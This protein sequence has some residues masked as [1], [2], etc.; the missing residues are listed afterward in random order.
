MKQAECSRASTGCRAVRAAD[1]DGVMLLAAIVGAEDVD[2]AGRLKRPSAPG[3]RRPGAATEARA[4]A[5][6]A[7]SSGSSVRLP[8]ARKRG[9]RPATGSTSGGGQ[10]MRR[11]RQP[12]RGA[13]QVGRAVAQGLER[14]LHRR[15]Q[16]IGRVGDRAQPVQAGVGGQREA[17]EIAVIGA[18]LQR[19]GAPR[20]DRQFGRA[21]ARAGRPAGLRDSVSTATT[22][23]RARRISQ[24]HGHAHAQ[25][26]AGAG[27]AF[28]DAGAKRHADLALFTPI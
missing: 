1:L 18:G 4:S 24:H 25:I 12:E 13:V 6:A 10:Q 16:V 14:A 8:L 15:P 23:A 21:H 3:P 9:R 20:G 2:A 7:R 28:D 27:Q 17:R 19:L 22:S 11:F 26:G 5:G